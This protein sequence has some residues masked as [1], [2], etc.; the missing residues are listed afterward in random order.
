MRLVAVVG[1][2][3]NE[4]GNHLNQAADIKV[5]FK[6]ILANDFFEVVPAV[7]RKH[8]LAVIDHYL[9]VLL[10]VEISQPDYDNKGFVLV[11]ICR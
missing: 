4:R 5:F 6:A 8:E 3:R 11:S 10:R 9:G 7:G 2:V 1:E